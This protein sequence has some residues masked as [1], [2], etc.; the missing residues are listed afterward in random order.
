MPVKPQGL[1]KLQGL[2]KAQGQALLAGSLLPHAGR[3]LQ[4]SHMHDTDI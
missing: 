1:A 2:V 3:H 4:L